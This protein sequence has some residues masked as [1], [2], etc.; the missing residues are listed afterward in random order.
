MCIIILS[1]YR[2]MPGEYLTGLKNAHKQCFKEAVIHI[3]ALL[4]KLLYI[5]VKSHSLTD[6][7]VIN[8]SYTPCVCCSQCTSVYGGW[9]CIYMYIYCILCV[10]NAAASTNHGSSSPGELNDAH[11]CR[12]GRECLPQ[13][14]LRQ[15][16][17]RARPSRPR[18]CLGEYQRAI[19]RHQ[20]HTISDNLHHLV[21]K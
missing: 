19:T 6:Y 7:Y 3:W 18:P 4:Y 8:I 5:P 13:R 9:I 10:Q 12:Q 1:I 2:G 21:W 14:A 11:T 17:T 16:M 15:H 20:W